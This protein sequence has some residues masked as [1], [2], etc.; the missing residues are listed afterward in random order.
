VF[1]FGFTY[2]FFLLPVPILLYFLLPPLRQQK[3]YMSV[4]FFKNFIELTGIH[5]KTGVS[6]SKKKIVNILT[7]S[8]IWIFLIAALASPRIVGKP[9]LKLKNAR[10]LMFAVDLSGS[11][12]TTDWEINGKRAT[13]WDAVKDVM[14]GFIKQREGDRIGLILF[15]T[16]AYLQVPFTSDLNVVNKYLQESEVGMPGERTAIGNAIGLG[17]KLFDADS[18]DRKVMILLTDG[19]DSGSEIN[20]IQAA[21]TAAADSVVIYTIGIGNP[22]AKIFDVD[23]P[24]MK[25]IAKDTN[26]K[27]FLAI[28][29]KQLED[30]YKTLDELEPIEYEEETYKPATL[31]YYYPLGI[32]IILALLNQLTF[33]F[34]SLFKKNH[35]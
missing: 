10:S 33:G 8:L 15:G 12:T 3:T 1:E 26:G 7:I 2:A 30:V 6:V 34:V 4:P 20:P 29:E 28:D 18:T 35:E 16:Q 19:V 21:R 17:V 14:A 9:E 22:V 23:E 5:G 11:M 13:R 25:Q 32:V 27:Y 31:L 24:M